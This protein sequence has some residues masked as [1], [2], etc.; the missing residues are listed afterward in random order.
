M[1]VT[2]RLER[3]LLLN[4]HEKPI[5]F[6]FDNA[7]R[8]SSAKGKEGNC[9]EGSH[10]LRSGARDRLLRSDRGRCKRDSG[11]RQQ[12]HSYQLRPKA[13]RHDLGQVAWIREEEKHALRRN[14][15]PL[16]ELKTVN[17]ARYR[18]LKSAVVSEARQSLSSLQPFAVF[19][20]NFQDLG[21][22]NSKGIKS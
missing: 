1:P 3:S 8:P 13:R 10:D 21:R 19:H 9:A 4:V 22:K 17:H 12:L 7:R 14:C 11:R 2:K 20:K 15:D 6:E 18:K 5:P 16:L